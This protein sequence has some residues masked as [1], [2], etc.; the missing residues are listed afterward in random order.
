MPI[1]K[2][3]IRVIIPK[4]RDMTNLQLNNSYALPFKSQAVNFCLKRGDCNKIIFLRKISNISKAS[5][6]ML[7][8]ETY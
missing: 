7:Y 5:F 8:T 3:Y 4:L 1:F 2:K 6:L